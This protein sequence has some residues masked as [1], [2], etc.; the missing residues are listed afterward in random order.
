M[1]CRSGLELST[2]LST[3]DPQGENLLAFREG[4]ASKP[5]TPMKLS[6]RYDAE[7]RGLRENGRWFPA[8]TV[9][10]KGSFIVG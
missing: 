10:A 2:K 9:D 4:P 3:L 5:R 6:P 8:A 7:V 1:L